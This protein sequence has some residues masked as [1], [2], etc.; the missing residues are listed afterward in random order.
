MPALEKQRTK[1]TVSDEHADA[2]AR[3]AGRLG[4]HQ[5]N[6]LFAQDDE[7]ARHAAAS[8]P[9]QFARHLG[10]LADALS[11][12]DGLERSERQRAAAS[13]SHGIDDDTGSGWIRAEL[14]PDDDQRMKAKLDA[15][16]TVLRAR[17]EHDGKRDD[18]LGAVALV[19]L[20]TSNRAAATPPA[21]VSIVIDLDP[22]RP[23]DARCARC[24]APARSTA[25]N[26]ASTRR[27]TV[28]LPA[29]QL[30]SHGL[31]DLAVERRAA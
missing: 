4:D 11:A 22:R 13:L 31:P 15:E 26:T 12:D 16:I 27:L 21:E 28:C 17:P 19:N 3:A 29:G 24:T 14:H 2:L 20:V 5:R 1:G 9:T 23:S 6:E 10:R 18:Q 25:A 8:T 7:L 30:H